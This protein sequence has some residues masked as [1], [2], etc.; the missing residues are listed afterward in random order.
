VCVERKLFV[1]RSS[2]PRTASH[3]VKRSEAHREGEENAGSDASA[4]MVD[5]LIGEPSEK[6]KSCSMMMSHN[7]SMSAI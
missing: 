2:F 1:Q 4:G 6:L 7:Q 3:L 5:I